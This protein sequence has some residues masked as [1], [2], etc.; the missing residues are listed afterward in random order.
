MKHYNHLAK[1]TFINP[2]LRLKS[3]HNYVI[4]L[5]CYC[6]IDILIR[7]A[8][9]FCSRNRDILLKSEFLNRKTIIKLIFVIERGKVLNV[10]KPMLSEMTS[11]RIVL[12]TTSVRGF[13]L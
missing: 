3:N 2:V 10:C 6:S 7:S 12:L 11:I 4:N 8:M 5:I 1:S 9:T 13:V